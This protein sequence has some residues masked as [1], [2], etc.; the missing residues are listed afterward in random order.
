MNIE[1]VGSLSCSIPDLQAKIIAPPEPSLLEIVVRLLF[2][3]ALFAA[4]T[5]CLAAALFL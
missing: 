4:A 3:A 2:E 1:Y 5:T